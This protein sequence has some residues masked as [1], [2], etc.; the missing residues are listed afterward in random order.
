[1]TIAVIGWLAFAASI[2]LSDKFSFGL[3]FVGFG[4]FAGAILYILLMVKCPKCKAPLGQAY[5]SSGFGPLRS[6]KLNFCPNCGVEMEA[7]YEH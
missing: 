1:M 4:L 3:S 2:V 6:Y 5:L 7:E